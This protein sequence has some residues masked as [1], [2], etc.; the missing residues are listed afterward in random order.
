MMIIVSQCS[1]FYLPLRIIFIILWFEVR[2]TIYFQGGHWRDN[3]KTFCAHDTCFCNSVCRLCPRG[4]DREDRHAA[5]AQPGFADR[6]CQAFIRRRDR[7]RGIPYETII[8][9]EIQARRDR[10]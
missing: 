4:E 10:K 6:R 3:E 7:R 9:R 2:Q 8:E 5:R 1:C